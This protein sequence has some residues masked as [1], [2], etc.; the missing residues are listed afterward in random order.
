MLIFIA[1]NL[2]LIFLVKSNSPYQELFKSEEIFYIG[3]VFISISA[4]LGLLK[5][6]SVTYNFDLFA[7]GTLLIWFTYWHQFYRDD[8]PMFYSF[9]I[10]FVLLTAIVSL[11]F[12]NRR[13]QFDAESINHIRYYSKMGVFDTGIIVILV[14]LSLTIKNHVMAYPIAMTVLILRFVMTA[15]LEPYQLRHH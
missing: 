8:A 4:F 7:T 10:Y 11:L 2:L 6:F 1:F 9:P 3:L 14:M 13:H 5:K 12:V 15:C